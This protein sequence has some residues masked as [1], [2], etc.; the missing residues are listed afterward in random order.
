[1][2][3]V[4]KSQIVISSYLQKKSRNKL[5]IQTGKVDGQQFRVFF[6]MMGWYDNEN[7]S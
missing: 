1:M 2:L 5:F 6:V 4:V 3:K 7:T